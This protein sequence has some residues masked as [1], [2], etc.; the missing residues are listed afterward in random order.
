M[1]VGIECLLSDDPSHALALAEKLSAINAQRQQLQSSMVEQAQ[2]MVAAFLDRHRGSD[3]LPH[4]VVLH[5]QDWHPGVVGLVASKLKECLNRPVVAFASVGRGGQERSLPDGSG[6]DTELRG[7]A[8]S[9]NGFHLRDALAEVDTNCPD[10]IVRFGG[11]AMAAGLTL[12]SA[13]LERFATEFDAVARR[14]IDASLLEQCVWSDG[15]LAS[16]DFSFDAAN[17]LRYGAPWGQGFA[18]PSFDNVFDVESWR[19]VG[20]RHLKLK[21]R[22]DGSDETFEAIMFNALDAIPPPSRLRAVYQL[23]I[24]NWNGRDRL[25]LRV[26]HI[27]AA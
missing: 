2:A 9:I 23:E 1:S 3:A 12:Q 22:L 25:Q 21:L 13:N 7:S 20:E 11:H 14:R 10:L 15:E 24:D 5:E 16:G 8:R 4:G 26:Q 17:A 19:A 18:E 27:D 6:Q